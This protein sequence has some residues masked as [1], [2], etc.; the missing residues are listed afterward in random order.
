MSSK[1]S[2]INLST[3]RA[4]LRRFIAAAIKLIGPIDPDAIKMFLR[5]DGKVPTPREL[6]KWMIDAFGLDANGPSPYFKVNGLADNG[7]NLYWRRIPGEGRIEAYISG[8]KAATI[9][10][11]V[12]LVLSMLLRREGI[13]PF[14]RADQSYPFAVEFFRSA[15]LMPWS[16]EWVKENIHLL[17]PH[18]LKAYGDKEFTL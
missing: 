3:S 10:A 14:E 15:K 13:F 9:Y 6:E 11:D 8:D 5:L 2:R 18:L 4:A 1:S 12:Y 16:R 17:P 7:M